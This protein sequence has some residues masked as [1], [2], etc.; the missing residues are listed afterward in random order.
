MQLHQYLQR[1]VAI[2][3]HFV[4]FFEVLYIIAGFGR[5]YVYK[6]EESDKVAVNSHKTL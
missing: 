4:G 3:R 5:N 6:V 1:F 2:H